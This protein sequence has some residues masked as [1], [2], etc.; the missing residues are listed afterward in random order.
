MSSFFKYVSNVTLLLVWLA[1]ISLFIAI[2]SLGGWLLTISSS[3]S[4]WWCTSTCCCD[5]SLFAPRLPPPSP[6]PPSIYSWFT[7]SPLSFK[8]CSFALVSDGSSSG[9]KSGSNVGISPRSLC[10]HEW[11]PNH[12]TNAYQHMWKINLKMIIVI[13][14]LISI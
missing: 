7:S 1:C 8:I 6:S 14:P 12:C 2:M 9:G 11:L 13:I 4:S 3:S 10:P 5:F